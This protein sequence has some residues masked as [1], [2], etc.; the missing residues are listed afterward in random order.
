M[1]RLVLAT[2]VLLTMAC[3]VSDEQELQLGSELAAEIEQQLPLVRDPELTG[4]VTSLGETLARGADERNLTWRF[5]IVDAEP[6]NA[7]AIPGGHIYV[8]RG[9]IERAGNLAELAGVLGHEIGHVTLRHSVEQLEKRQKTSVGV[10]IVCAL[11]S[12]CSNE[13]AQVAINVGGAALF[14]RHSRQD[15]LEAD[16]EGVRNVLRAGVDPGGIPSLFEKL[17]RDRERQPAIVEG[18]FGTHPLEEDRIENARRL[19][20]ELAP[21]ASSRLRVDD[22]SFQAFQARVRSL[23]P[24]PAPT[25]LPASTP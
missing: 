3:A 22:P 1:G 14:A 10:A 24:S 23:P 4:Y 12:F 9:L 20:S 5:S 19:I 11:T 7:F 18:W 25:P 13:V 15:E 16:A 6:V 21:N 17:M 2:A 8:N